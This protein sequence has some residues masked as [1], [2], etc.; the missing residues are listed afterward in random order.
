MQ[1]AQKLEEQDRQ[2][3]LEFRKEEAEKNHKHE[4]EM[5]QLYLRMMAPQPPRHQTHGYAPIPLTS[6]PRQTAPSFSN[7]SI[8]NEFVSHTYPQ[9]S[10]PVSE[11]VSTRG[12]IFSLSNIMA[13]STS[14]SRQGISKST[15]RTANKT[16]L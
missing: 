16:I 1:S 15:R 2:L 12:S 7:I 14:T 3:L 10:S 13:N 4:Q 9:F 5:A 8:G 11:D 6:L